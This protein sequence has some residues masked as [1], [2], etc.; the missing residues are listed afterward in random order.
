MIGRFLE[1]G[2]HALVPCGCLMQQYQMRGIYRCIPGNANEA[3]FS[4]S[5]NWSPYESVFSNAC[6]EYKQALSKCPLFDGLAYQSM[7]SIPGLVWV[8]EGRGYTV[9]KEY[10]A[11]S[12]DI[13]GEVGT[14]GETCLYSLSS[15]S[16]GAAAGCHVQGTGTPF[17]RSRSL[18]SP[19]LNL[20]FLLACLQTA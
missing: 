10:V 11:G 2:S 6:G 4:A 7:S 9:A 18:L 16:S 1:A 20:V 19:S 17:S 15:N 5:C 13:L 8:K 12:G 14:I 3:C